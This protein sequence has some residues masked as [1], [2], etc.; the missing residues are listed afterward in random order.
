MWS[1]CCLRG[2]MTGR[3]FLD[4]IVYPLLGERLKAPVFNGFIWRYLFS[5][6]ILR[7]KQIV[8]E[9]AY[10]EDEL[11][12]MEYF[13]NAQRLAVTEEPLYR[14]FWNPASATHRYMRNFE[15][16]FHRF[17]ERKEAVVKRYELSEARAA[18]AGKYQLGG[19]AD[20]RGE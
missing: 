17:L 3:E 16:V 4:G 9:G 6:E 7:D 8:F 15:Q 14:Y 12:L 5:N 10:L 19:V 20:C 18:V 11:F 2:S 13:C 1:C